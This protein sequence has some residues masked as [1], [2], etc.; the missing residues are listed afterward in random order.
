MFQT[1]SKVCPFRVGINCLFCVCVCAYVRALCVCVCISRGYFPLLTDIIAYFWCF[2]LHQSFSLQ[3]GNPL[4]ILCVC[5]CAYVRA[6]CVWVCECISRS[7]CPL[8][9]DLKV[10]L[11]CFKT[12]QRFPLSV[13]DFPVCFVCVHACVP[14]CVPCVWE[15]VCI[16]PSYSPL[17][18]DIKAYLWCFKPHQRFTNSVWESP[19]CF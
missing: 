18:T 12:H 16:S 19:V 10:Y 8:Q 1:T 6:L 14:T 15:C 13:W 11:W 4:F 5:V 9:T 2:Q 7:Y 3:C 17:L